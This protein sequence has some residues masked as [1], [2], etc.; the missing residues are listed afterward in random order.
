MRVSNLPTFLLTFLTYFPLLR[1]NTASMFCTRL[2]LV[3]GKPT[4]NSHVGRQQE[5]IKG[6]RY[7]ILGFFRPFSSTKKLFICSTSHSVSEFRV[8][9]SN[10]AAHARNYKVRLQHCVNYEIS[11]LHL[12]H[13]RA[14]FV[15]FFRNQQ[16]HTHWDKKL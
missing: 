3:F 7:W 16:H 9:P 4:A 5:P 1:R 2:F 8:P 10:Y 13:S 12:C 14:I 6:K 15:F 11:D